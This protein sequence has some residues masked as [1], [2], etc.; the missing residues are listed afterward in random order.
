MIALPPWDCVK[1]DGLGLSG[2]NYPGR[3]WCPL[4]LLVLENCGYKMWLENC[5]YI[6]GNSYTN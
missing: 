4:L 5:G 3:G 1:L 6:N 2:S